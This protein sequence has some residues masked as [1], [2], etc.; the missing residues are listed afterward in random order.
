MV[1]F[2][3]NY[4]KS[5]SIYTFDIYLPFCLKFSLRIIFWGYVFLSLIFDINHFF[6]N[7]KIGTF[8]MMPTWPD[9]Q[10]C[11]DYEIIQ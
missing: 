11:K 8:G 1:L 7:I 10:F 5:F 9:M 4:L 6:K 2:L 3:R